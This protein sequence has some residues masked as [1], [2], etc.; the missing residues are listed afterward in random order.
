MVALDETAA[1]AVMG[2]G[3]AVVG[4]WGGT[5]AQKASTAISRPS[6]AD[7]RKDAVEGGWGRRRT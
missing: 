2:D 1:E 7:A 5:A 3:D 6:E 4:A